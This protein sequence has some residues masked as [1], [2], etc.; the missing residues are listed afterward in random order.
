MQPSCIIDPLFQLNRHN[1]TNSRSL[2]EL[3]SVTMASTTSFLNS[4]HTIAL[5]RMTNRAK[6]VPSLICPTHA[7]THT[8]QH[9]AQHAHHQYLAGCNAHD[10]G[11]ADNVPKAPVKLALFLLVQLGDELLVQLGPKVLWMQQH[12][13]RKLLL[14][15]PQ[16]E[17]SPR[18][19]Y[20][21]RRRRGRTRKNIA[22]R[23]CRV[24]KEIG[25]TLENKLASACRREDRKLSAAPLRWPQWLSAWEERALCSHWIFFALQVWGLLFCCARSWPS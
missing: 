25:A 19:R 14:H 21:Q 1:N 4:R 22:T 15:S 12:L 11:H 16:R 8:T 9:T 5:N 2:T 10:L 3:T 18:Q 6:P 24:R 20:I 17:Q 23:R 7:R 13:V